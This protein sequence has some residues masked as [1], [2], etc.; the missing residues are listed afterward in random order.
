[1]MLAFIWL[2]WKSGFRLF[3]KIDYELYKNSNFLN[4]KKK[5]N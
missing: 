3:R 2:F 1:M 4:S 5:K